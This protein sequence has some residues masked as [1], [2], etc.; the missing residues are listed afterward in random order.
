MQARNGIEGTISELARGY[1]MRRCR[2]RGLT[3]ARLQNWFIAAACNIKRWC[4]RQVWEFRQA[5]GASD[6]GQLAGVSS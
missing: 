3:K 2:Y 4:R 1:G 5:L 6:F